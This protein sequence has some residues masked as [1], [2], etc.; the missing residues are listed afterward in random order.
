MESYRMNKPAFDAFIANNAE[1]VHDPDDPN[2]AYVVDY[3]PFSYSNCPV[4]NYGNDLYVVPIRTA[5]RFTDQ[6]W[7]VPDKLDLDAINDYVAEDE[8]AQAVVKHLERKGY[9]VRECGYNDGSMWADYVLAVPKN[10]GDPQ[11]YEDEINA[12]LAGDVYTVTG[13]FYDGEEWREGYTLGD[14]YLTDCAT[15]E[16]DICM[17][18]R[19]T[20]PYG[21]TMTIAA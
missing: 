16:D 8:T 17:V 10:A 1:V 6:C 3:D 9:A 2:A 19:D 15:R 21:M 14:V 11:G 13:W 4:R 20:M 7:H 12:W 5:S 18:G